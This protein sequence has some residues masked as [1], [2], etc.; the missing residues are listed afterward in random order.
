M[1]DDLYDLLSHTWAWRW[2]LA[3]GQITAIDIER[4]REKRTARLAVAYEFS[5]GT[6][7]PYTGESFWRPQFAEERRVGVARKKLHL[8]QEVTIRD[9]PDDPS[10]N[11]L[12]GGVSS[13]LKAA[14]Q[15]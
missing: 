13:L 10:M 14:T 4:N 2:P 8:H 3:H 15:P 11:S 5:V 7:G 1:F 12:R 6:D 9:R